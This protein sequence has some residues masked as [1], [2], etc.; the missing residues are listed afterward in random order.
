M[1]ECYKNDRKGFFLLSNGSMCYVSG[2]CRAV[3]LNQAA[4]AVLQN[5]L[6]KGEM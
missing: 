2:Q 1:H 4:K 6:E 5:H 3:S